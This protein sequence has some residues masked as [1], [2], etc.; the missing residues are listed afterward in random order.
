MGNLDGQPIK[1][2]CSFFCLAS[3]IKNLCLPTFTDV[4]STPN[5]MKLVTPRNF[6]LSLAESMEQ[7]IPADVED[8]LRHI[9]RNFVTTLC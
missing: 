2:I 6:K 8:L 3:T 1:A 9:S 4:L 7:N 5:A